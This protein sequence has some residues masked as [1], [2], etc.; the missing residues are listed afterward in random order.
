MQ[1][2]A[3]GLAPQG[4]DR[5]IF[6]NEATSRPVMALLGHEMTHS[7]RVSHPGLYNKLEAY[8]YHTKE[9]DL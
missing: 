8:G 3:E 1:Q 9:N 4:K 5:V 7:M 2:F 6:I